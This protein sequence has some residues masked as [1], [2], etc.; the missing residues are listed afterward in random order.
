MAESAAETGRAAEKEK[1]ILFFK[2]LTFSS[3]Y[4]EARAL[5]ISLTFLC[6]PGYSSTGVI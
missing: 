3:K 6:L 2:T 1:G 5:K 4:V